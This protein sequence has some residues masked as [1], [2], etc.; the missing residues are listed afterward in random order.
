MIYFELFFIKEIKLLTFH[1]TALIFSLFLFSFFALPGNYCYGIEIEESHSYQ[2]STCLENQLQILNIPAESWLPTTLSIDSTPLLDVAIIGG[3]MNGLATSLALIKEGICNIK[4]FDE[5]TCGREGPWSR[6]ARMN[7]LR[8]DKNDL[9]PALGIPGLTFRAWYEV[10]YGQDGWNQLKSVPTHMWNDYLCWFRK[11][12]N[13]PVENNIALKSII[14]LHNVLKLILEK[15]GVEQIVY[16]RKVVLAT[17]RDGSGGFEVPEFMKNISPHL[18]AHSAQTIDAESLA[19]KKV[20]IIG[21][22]ASAFDAAAVALEHGALKVDIVIRRAILPSANKFTHFT[23]P[24]ASLG[25]FHMEDQERWA[26]F[27]EWLDHGIPPPK[28][29][30]ERVKHYQNLNVHYSTHIKKITEDDASAIITTSQGDITADFIIIATGFAVDLSRRPELANINNEIL[31]WD[32]CVP[33]ELRVNN[34]KLGRFPYLGPHLEFLEAHPGN[35]PYLKNIYCFNYGAFLSHG[36]LGGDIGL[37]TLGAMRLA[38][39]IVIDFFLENA[40]TSSR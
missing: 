23:Q 13:L 5:N 27:A 19:N 29:T 9:G 2:T 34:V 35:A 17:G 25:F 4:V 36:L 28:E 11:I 1:L 15:G 7:V 3:G 21:G 33:E 18:Y 32:A 12:L 14:P 31:L 24:G 16:A 37:N 22:G 40:R 38:E 20:A 6:Y 8:S 30:L 10:Q 39:G 26:C